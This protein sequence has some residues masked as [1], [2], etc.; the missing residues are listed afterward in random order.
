MTITIINLIILL[1][2]ILILGL[3]IKLYT[4]LLKDKR[5][6]DRQEKLSAKFYEKGRTP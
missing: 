5:I 2:N 4:E 3:V 6:A 1:S